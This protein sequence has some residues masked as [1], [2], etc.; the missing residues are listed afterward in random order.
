MA[1]HPHESSEFKGVS[2]VVHSPPQADPGLLPPA[3]FASHIDQERRALTGRP[4]AL[5]GLGPLSS[6]RGTH[7]PTVLVAFLGDDFLEHTRPRVQ[8]FGDCFSGLNR[9]GVDL[10]CDL[11]SPGVWS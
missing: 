11:G 5:G 9:P 8:E 10:G 2:V 4:R 1:V 6:P 7:G 3:H